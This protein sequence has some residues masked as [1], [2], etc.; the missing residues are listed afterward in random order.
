MVTITASNSD[1]KEDIIYELME[2]ESAVYPE[3]M[4]G[5]YA[6]IKARFQ[7][8][9]EMFF[10][11]HDQDKIV[12]YFCFLPISQRVYDDVIHRGCFRDDDI[13]PE[14]ILTLET[15]RHVYIL[16]V[17]LYQ[18]FQNKGIADKM[19]EEFE[20][21]VY[22]KNAEGCRIEDIVAATV[23]ADGE[24]LAKRYGFKLHFDNWEKEGFKVYVRRL[25]SSRSLSDYGTEA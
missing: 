5:E 22:D 15:A 9:P 7:K 13:A 19:M 10:L 21:L 3:N 24:K 14:D 25:E 1:T 6:S 23:T 18:K 16:S 8:W 11:A 4:R 12:G 2:I 17:A 20:K